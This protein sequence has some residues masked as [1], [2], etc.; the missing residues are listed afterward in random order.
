MAQAL[1]NTIV[2]RNCTE[3]GPDGQRVQGI[4]LSALRERPAYV[5]LGEP[6]A[7]KS[8][9][10]EQEAE[11][12][13]TEAIRAR[14]FVSLEARPEWKDK[15][16]FIDGLDEM[17]AGTTDG[18]TQ[19]NAIRRK[20]EQLGRPPF[21]LSCREAE[22]LGASDRADLARV[23]PDGAITVVHLDDLSPEQIALLLTDN[24]GVVAPQTFIDKAKEHRLETLLGNPQTLG[25]LAEAVRH[26]WPDSL[27]ETYALACRKLAEETNKRHRDARR[28]DIIVSI[29]DLLDAAGHACAVQLLAG[30]AGF[31]LDQDAIDDSHPSLEHLGL[32]ATPALSRALGSRLFAAHGRDEQREPTHRRI[33][34]Y[35]GA[36][37]LAHRIERDKLPLGRVMALMSAGDGGIV[38]D[39]RGLH[40]WLA[41]HCLSARSS[42]IERDPLGVVLYGDLRNFS[43]SDKRRL[44]DALGRE[45]KRYPWFRS[46]DWE[47]PPFGALASPDMSADFL[48]ILTDDARDEAHESLLDCMLEAISHGQPMPEL[49]AALIALIRDGKHWP[50]NRHQAIEAYVRTDGNSPAPLLELLEDINSGAV[51]DGDDELAGLLLRQLYPTHLSATQVVACLHSAKS[52]NL[53]G[54]YL[55]FWEHELIERT[56]PQN[57]PVL[58]DCFAE[59]IDA[60]WSSQDDFHI[61]RIIGELLACGLEK[62]GTS[63]LLAQLWKWLGIGL[64]KS[65]YCYLDFDH[66]TRIANWLSAHPDIYR[67]LLQFALGLCDENDDAHLCFLR[68]GR[69][70]Y[71]S[72]MPPGCEDW[73][74]AQASAAAREDIRRQLFDQGA[75]ALLRRLDY[76]PEL[77]ATLLSIAER[78]PELQSH[79]DSWLK[80]DWLE[81]RQEEAKRKIERSEQD[82]TRLSKWISYFREN[83]TAIENGTAIATFMHDL[84]KAYFGRYYEA[85]GDTPIER[86]QTFFGNDVGIIQT[87]LTGLRH[88]LLR[89]DLPSVAEIIDLATKSRSHYIAEACLAGTEELARDGVGAVLAL[90]SEVLSRL[91]AFRLAHNYGNTPS[92]FL[93]AVEQQPDIVAD[94]VIAHGAAMLKSRKEHISGLYPLAHDNTYRQ[95]ARLAAVPL[96]STYPLRG[97]KEHL[98]LLGTLLVAA[99][100]HGDREALL[101]L[102]ATKLSLPSLDNAQRSQWLSAGLLLDSLHYEPPLNRYVG[103]N[104]ARALLVAG[105]FGSQP[106]RG[107]D[108]PEFSEA[109][110]AL[111]IR[112]LA[113]HTSPE[114]PSGA[115]RVSAEMNAADLVRSLISRLAA[116]PSASASTAFN[117]L[118]VFKGLAPWHAFLR[119]HQEAQRIVSREAH[120]QRLP[121]AA[122]VRTLANSEPANAADLMALLAQHLQDMAHEDRDGNTTGYLRFWNVDSDGKPENPRPENDCRDR[123]LELLRERLRPTALELQPEGE[124]RENKRAD[125]RVSFGGSTGFNL[126]I[127]IKRSFHDDLWRALRNQLMAHYVRD[128]GADGHGIYLVFWFGDKGQ[129]VPADGGKRPRSTAELENRLRAMLNPEE[130]RRIDVIVMNCALPGA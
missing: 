14:D 94:V 22:W 60:P 19:L 27:A 75:L 78:Y 33:A 122:V 47:A 73:C 74:F 69:R 7:G 35:L 90:K 45:A 6:G 114:R 39:L 30:L 126:P 83:Q 26:A 3:I 17:R 108:F 56:T 109:T 25:M 31:A 120:F 118:L 76:T 38:S 117:N 23:A 48:G 58:L 46:Q 111:L 34:E 54:M 16:I 18:Q 53:I 100:K 43:A 10:F 68:F 110:M 29:D 61:R 104:Q 116:Q 15:P 95:V 42:L 84:A 88:C 87:T 37:F 65:T 98:S 107:Q 101:N 21:R 57:F 102:I 82:R 20:L 63:A 113:T 11:A 55:H 41:V 92:W 124:Y 80:D 9:S 79:V 119:H 51:P 103:T 85:K 130:Q 86:L 81:W 64:S 62:V 13:G 66:K 129:P 89:D 91:I 50:R 96:L 12:A 70:F 24:H 4:P 8:T 99:I 93:A 112:L 123:L 105:F 5:L 72:P 1:V 2:S 71:E 115:Y 52:P 32:T 40:A 125:I 127:E 97:K 59:N 67:G 36:R 128:P 77:L 44:L 28:Q 121:A 49:G 106:S